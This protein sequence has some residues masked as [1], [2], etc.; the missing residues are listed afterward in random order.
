MVPL[1][2]WRSLDSELF[3]LKS[4][5]AFYFGIK[6]RFSMRERA[7]NFDIIDLGELV[8]IIHDHGKKAYL[9]T[10]ILIYNNEIEDLK[11]LIE[12]AVSKEVDAIIC[13]DP[14]TIIL[15][16]EA[17]IPFHISTQANISNYMAAKFYF[18]LGAQR[19]ILA[20]ELDIE[21]IRAIINYFHQ[22]ITGSSH[23]I[24]EFEVFIHGAMCTAIS[25]RC[26]L[27]SEIM[28]F[29]RKYSANRGKCVQPCRR[30]Y[31]IKNPDVILKNELVQL[32]EE[33][34]TNLEYDQLT[35]MFFNAKD[36]CMIEH[37]DDLIETGVDSFKIEGRMRDP[38]YISETSRV[39]REAIDA[40]FRGDGEYNRE[41]ITQWLN[42]LH[43]VFN[44]GFHTGFYYDIPSIKDIQRKK[45]GNI[46]KTKKVWIGRVVNYYKKANALELRLETGQIKI[47]DKLIFEN[48]HIFHVQKITSIMI[49]G[50]AVNQ[51]PFV[52][53][54][55]KIIVG[56]AVNRFIPKNSK[57]F[58]IKEG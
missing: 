53:G 13:H 38:L 9:T 4:G 55:N 48:E 51:T 39:Y 42:T 49:D 12:I 7:H 29:N 54:K 10:N 22:D 52:R 27:S 45:R 23:H 28:G 5:D 1:N 16:K 34:G 18:N 47:N 6:N 56:L 26:Y 17:G 14:S 46:S 57:V 32:E 58:L 2:D 33:E 41:N 25:G 36:L 40:Y 11:K 31:T 30:Q 3:T 24:H 43:K 44:R 21:Q 35:G 37:L 20:R 50:N 19:L 8:K 15:A